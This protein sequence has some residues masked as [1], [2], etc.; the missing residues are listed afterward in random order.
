MDGF[1]AGPRLC[2]GM[3]LAYLEE[4]LAL[5]SVYPELLVLK[6]INAYKLD[7]QK[8]DSSTSSNSRS[9]VLWMADLV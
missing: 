4:K 1:G 6:V 5:V 8:Q 7:D 3:R 9:P 2:M